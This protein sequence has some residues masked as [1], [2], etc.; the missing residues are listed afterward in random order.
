MFSVEYSSPPKSITSCS[1]ECIY[2]IR[3]GTDGITEHPTTTYIISH[4]PQHPK[5]QNQATHTHTQSFDALLSPGTY[6]VHRRVPQRA[7]AR[8]TLLCAYRN[9]FS[10]R[11]CS[12]SSIFNHFRF[13]SSNLHPS[14]PS[15]ISVFVSFTRVSFDSKNFPHLFRVIHSNRDAKHKYEQ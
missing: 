8:A 15:C 11:R 9:H 6:H 13:I 2:V 4:V 12:S 10:I 5:P 3:S 1:G 14:S 7:L